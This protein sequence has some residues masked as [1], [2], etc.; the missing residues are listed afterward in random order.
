MI[1]I[2]ILNFIIILI[3]LGGI[4]LIYAIAKKVGYPKVGF[5]LAGFMGALFFYATITDLYR[6][7]LFSKADA[8]ELL[9]E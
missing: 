8:K 6:D 7:E 2:G 9:A 3:F 1:F 4:F 5:A